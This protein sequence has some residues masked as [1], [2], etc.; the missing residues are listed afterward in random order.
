MMIFAFLSGC[1]KDRPDPAI[2]SIVGKWHLDAYEKLV[3]G[4]KVWEKAKDNPPGY[5]SFRFDGIMLD[6][7]DLPSCCAP[8]GYN[9]NGTFFKIKPKASLP[10]LTSSQVCSSQIRVRHETILPLGL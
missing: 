1:K 10:S 9:L 2:E 6:S 3:N 7:K 5:L 4:D 8:A